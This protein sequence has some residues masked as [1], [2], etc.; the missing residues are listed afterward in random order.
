MPSN[1]NDSSSQV[2]F[3]EAFRKLEETVQAL[4]EGNLSLE[5]ATSL[6]EEGIGLAKEC[7]RLLSAT[8]LKITQLK[9]SYA[10]DLEDPSLEET[11]NIAE[12]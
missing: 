4:E 5:E 10:Q 3:E 11:E 8:E 9:E 1:N 12:G 6:Y 7:N 2:S